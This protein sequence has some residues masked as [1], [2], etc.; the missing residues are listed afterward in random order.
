M[1]AKKKFIRSF[2]LIKTSADSAETWFDIATKNTFVNLEGDDRINWKKRGYSTLSD[3]LMV[4]LYF[5]KFT[6]KKQKL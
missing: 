6:I 2:G 5:K 1:N 3:L 4:R